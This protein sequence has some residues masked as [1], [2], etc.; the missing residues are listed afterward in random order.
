MTTVTLNKEQRLYVQNHGDHFT[1]LGFDVAFNKLESLHK[2]LSKMLS[3]S[4]PEMPKYKGTMKVYNMLKKLEK[5]A[6]NLYLE[7]G[8][9]LESCLTKQ[10]IGL[11]GKRVEVV[12]CYNETRRFKVGR[13]TGWLPFH[14]E[15]SNERSVSGLPVTSA[16]FKSVR[17]IS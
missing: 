8:I 2:E 17:V 14:I 7:H 15:L 1:C 12:D 16:P 5:I 6:M 13:S 10:L 3:K 4:L 11:E 9:K